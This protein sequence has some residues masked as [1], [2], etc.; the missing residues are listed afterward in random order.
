MRTIWYRSFYD[1]A[2]NVRFHMLWKFHPIQCRMWSDNSGGQHSGDLYF[3]LS[4]NFWLT[5]DILIVHLFNRAQKVFWG[6]RYYIEACEIYIWTLSFF[7]CI[8]NLTRKYRMP[9]IFQ[10]IFSHEFM[11]NNYS[12]QATRNTNIEIN[13]SSVVDII[14]CL[15]APIP[16]A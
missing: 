5:T 12:N 4:N 6:K 14:N 13:I 9:I 7:K 15:P 11:I 16:A 3:C 1:S 2:K 8:Y 10:I